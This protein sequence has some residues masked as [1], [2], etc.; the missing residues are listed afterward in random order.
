MKAGA[1]KKGRGAQ[2]NPPNPYETQ[3]RD[4]TPDPEAKTG[5]QYQAVHPKTLLNKV[6]SPDIG[7]G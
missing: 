6:D 2:I 3:I 1:Y 4:R 7:M 5:T